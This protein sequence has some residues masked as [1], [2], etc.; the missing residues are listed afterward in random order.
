MKRI[1]WPVSTDSTTAIS[2]ARATIA[3]ATACRMR[4][5]CS[6]GVALQAPKLARA[7][8]VAAEM[9]AESPAATSPRCIP[10]MGEALANVS[11]ETLGLGSPPM[12]CRVGSAA[13][14]ARC[15]PAAARFSSKLATVAMVPLLWVPAGEARCD[16]AARASPRPYRGVGNRPCLTSRVTG[17]RPRRTAREM[18]RRLEAVAVSDL[19]DRAPRGHRWFRLEESMSPEPSRRPWPRHVQRPTDSYPNGASRF[20]TRSHSLTSERPREART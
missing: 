4:L 6:P 2:S 15:R 5:R 19:G 16:P 7:A 11:P 18:G 14:R 20:A 3:S 17:R 12:R 10:S 9:S 13:K 8:S 1:A